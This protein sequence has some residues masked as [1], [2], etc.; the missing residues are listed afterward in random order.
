[1][2]GNNLYGNRNVKKKKYIKLEKANNLSSY[3]IERTYLT[4]NAT[5]G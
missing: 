5:K 3:K 4:E 1:M 2:L